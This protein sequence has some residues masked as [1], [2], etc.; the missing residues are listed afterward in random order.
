MLAFFKAQ[1]MTLMTAAQSYAK[2]GLARLLQAWEKLAVR[3]LQS[4]YPG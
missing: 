3:S 4:Q 2:K 1:G